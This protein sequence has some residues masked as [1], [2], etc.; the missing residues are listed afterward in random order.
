MA[1]NRLWLIH[2]PTGAHVCLGK[3]MAIGWHSTRTDN[4]TGELIREFF[5]QVEC[6]P[7][8]GQDDFVLALEDAS[9]APS[10]TEIFDYYHDASGLHPKLP[11]NLIGQ[12]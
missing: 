1:N 11:A 8:I 3:R 4:R 2:R 7:E 6:G 5:D 10:A 9:G 12:K